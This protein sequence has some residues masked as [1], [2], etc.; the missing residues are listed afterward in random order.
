M[1][2]SNAWKLL[3][4]FKRESKVDN[5]LNLK[6]GWFSCKKMQVLKLDFTLRDKASRS[7]NIA[8]TISRP[9]S[10]SIN[11]H[12]HRDTEAKNQAILPDL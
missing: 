10:F 2:I 8:E 12:K 7:G 3:N 11:L 9:L 1:F 5:V 4:A 6:M